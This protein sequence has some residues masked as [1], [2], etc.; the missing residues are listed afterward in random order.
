MYLKIHIHLLILTNKKVLLFNYHREF[1]S[2]YHRNVLDIIPARSFYLYANIF[3]KLFRFVISYPVETLDSC[4]SFQLHDFCNRIILIRIYQ[5]NF[6][7]I[8]RTSERCYSSSYEYT[9]R[10]IVPNLFIRQL[11]FRIE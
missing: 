10:D 3:T 7:I 1:Y 8:L 9:R 6:H 11:R 2:K 5:E 4:N